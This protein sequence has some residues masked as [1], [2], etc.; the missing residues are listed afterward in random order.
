VIAF[1]F[2]LGFGDVDLIQRVNSFWFFIA[3]LAVGLIGALNNVF[4]D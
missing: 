4:G 3:A 1:L 2:G